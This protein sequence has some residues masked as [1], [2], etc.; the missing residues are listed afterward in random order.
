[1]APKEM[2]AANRATSPRRKVLVRMALSLTVLS[3]IYDLLARWRASK[4]G[5]ADAAGAALLLG[6]AGVSD[7]PAG[8]GQAC[9][10]QF[11]IKRLRPA[12]QRGVQLLQGF[13]QPLTQFRRQ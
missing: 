6:K 11:R 5:A 10:Q 3:W 9:M 13:F 12:G 2:A 1:M 7:A 4:A 8:A